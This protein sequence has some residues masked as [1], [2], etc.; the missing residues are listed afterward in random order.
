MQFRLRTLLIILV[1][2]PPIIAGACLGWAG[3]CETIRA[4]RLKRQAS[5]GLPAPPT[6]TVPPPTMFTV[7]PQI[8]VQEENEETPVE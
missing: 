2:C 4:D 6:K 8:N 1:L 3:M 5:K 7:T